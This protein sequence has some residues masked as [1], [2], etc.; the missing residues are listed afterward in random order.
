MIHLK[1]AVLK[2][3]ISFSYTEELRAIYGDIMTE[4]LKKTDFFL[5]MESF[6]DVESCVVLL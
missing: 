4:K 2:G 6:L 5:V 1:K 3:S